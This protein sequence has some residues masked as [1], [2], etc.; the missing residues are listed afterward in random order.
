MIWVLPLLLALLFLGSWG[1][2]ALVVQRLFSS[3]N[4]QILSNI[5]PPLQIAI[6]VCTFSSVSG[7]LVAL[8]LGL[9][10]VLIA[11]HVIGILILCRIKRRK[12]AAVKSSVRLPHI[13][14][15]GPSLLSLAFVYW[16]SVGPSIAYPYID[17]NDDDASYIYFTKRLLA[18]GNLIDPFNQR[19]LVSYGASTVYQSMFVAITGV[20]SI[21]GFDSC[22]ALLLTVLLVVRTPKRFLAPA[23]IAVVGILANVGDG[24]VEISDTSPVFIGTALTIAILQL[25]SL[26]KSR[27][28]E[29]QK[30]VAILIGLCLSGLLSHRLAYSLLPTI[31]VVLVVV[32]YIRGRNSLK[33]AAYVAASA[34]FATIGWAVELWRSSGTPFFP[35]IDGNYNPSW[36]GLTA[37]GF[38]L[39]DV[40]SEAE[41]LRNSTL[42]V[43]IFTIAC[44][45]LV[46]IVRKNCRN[47]TTAVLLA[48][49]VAA[50]LSLM[51]FVYETSGT[52]PF[53]VV[54]YLCPSIFG[55]ALFA[56][57]SFWPFSGLP[58]I[59]ET[60]VNVRPGGKRTG[61]YRGG[62]SAASVLVSCAIAV[63]PLYE[64]AG[65]T[66][67][68]YAKFFLGKS[69]WSAGIGALLQGSTEVAEGKIGFGDRYS[70]GT[71]DAYNALSDVI[72]K[73][74][75][76]LA[77]VDAPGLLNFSRFSFATLDLVGAVSPVPH[78]PIFGTPSEIVSYLRNLG[79]GYIVADSPV[80]PGLYN[81]AQW[82]SDLSGTA[83]TYE[84]LAQYFVTWQKVVDELSR[85]RSYQTVHIGY[86]T[87]IKIR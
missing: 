84:R 70:S 54:R 27:S 73:G 60:W 28:S 43:P 9:L 52:G 59:T 38:T 39:A 42:S 10:R 30:S 55:C 66:N 32:L 20:S 40:V 19:R 64:N 67:G 6:G 4:S 74:A 18:T 57:E 51:A 48:S 7:V 31:S 44:M 29:D 85:S 15:W 8:S 82:K 62:L 87:V 50:Y 16:L 56:F 68:G 80:N 76:V 58:S 23:V 3:S 12:L 53:N 77:A 5:G 17:L 75:K 26:L 33:L 36:P 41:S 61:K 86:F 24:I 47:G 21:R 46:L 45:T 49:C 37:P 25:T 1:W 35:I 71:V 22:F 81:Y 2:G 14:R 79:Y 69:S 83:Y 78:M 72:P 11:W 63:F 65:S 34:T 13:L